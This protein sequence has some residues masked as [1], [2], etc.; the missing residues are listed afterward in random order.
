MGHSNKPKNGRLREHYLNLELGK[1]MALLFLT[2]GILPI[3]L[4]FGIAV[5]RI[6]R[7]S[8]D[9]Q[10]YMLNK[11]FEQTAQSIDDMLRRVYRVSTMV[12][13]YDKVREML[14]PGQNLTQIEELQAFE[15]ISDYTYE[16]EMSSEDITVLYY[17]NDTFIIADSSNTCFRSMLRLKDTSLKECLLEN[18]GRALWRVVKEKNRY[19]QTEEYLAVYRAVWNEEKYSEMIGATAVMIPVR[20]VQQALISSMRNQVLYLQDERGYVL[21]SSGKIPGEM[22]DLPEGGLQETFEEMMLGEEEY[23]V[24]EKEMEDENLSLV[25]A[26]LAEEFSADTVRIVK[27]MFL[28]FLGICALAAC[29][30]IRVSRHILRRIK[31]LDKGMETVDHGRLEKLDIPEYRDEVGRLVTRYNKMVDK[32]EELLRQQYVLGKEKA[33]AQLQALQSQ[34]NPHFLYN[35]LDMISWMARKNEMGNIQTALLAVSRF[36]RMVL[37]RGQDIVPIKREIEMCSAYMEI[38]RLRKKDKIRFIMEADESLFSYMIPK[39][40]LQP[41]IENAV[42]H[43]IEE[44]EDGKGTITVRAFSEKDRII[45][46]VIDDGAGVRQDSGIKK[47]GDIKEVHESSHYGLYNIQRRLSL[48]Y[49]EDIKIDVKSASGIGTEVTIRIPK[50]QEE[51]STANIINNG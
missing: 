23:L 40:T 33:N 30:M 6:A 12:T 22:K 47:E 49:E 51:T 16:V 41:I 46:Q 13:V 4:L 10:T 2:A 8:Q 42:V 38:Q 9:M 50:K 11:G 20:C 39:I 31:M 1:K 26:A 34:I 25:S 5:F 43:G 15:E 18:N 3:T 27:E 45:L 17:I 48:Y 36:Y 32:I 37:S 7:N 28:W 24:C 35:T 21:V 14:Q 19:G 44:K 29:L